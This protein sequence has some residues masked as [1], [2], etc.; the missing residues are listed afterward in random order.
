M[1]NVAGDI[2]LTYAVPEPGVAMLLF[3]GLGSLLGMRRRREI[4]GAHDTN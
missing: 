3:G 1:N 4:T 2:V